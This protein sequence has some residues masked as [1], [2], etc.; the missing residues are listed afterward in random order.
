MHFPVTDLLVGVNV[1]VVSI[2]TTDR[3]CQFLIQTVP[4]LQELVIATTATGVWC[5][6]V[7]PAPADPDN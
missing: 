6:Q 3:S 2:I 7:T 4:Q 1:G 5:R